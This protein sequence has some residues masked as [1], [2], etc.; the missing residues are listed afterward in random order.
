MQRADYL[1]LFG[2]E[3]GKE[4][5]L[6]REALAHALDIRKFEI[7]TYWK[8][9]TYFWA[10]IAVSFGGFFAL[11][12]R[13]TI[14]AF[15]VG[16][17]G[18]LFSVGWYLVNRGSGSW[19]RNWEA[20]VDLLEDEVMGPLHKTLI[21]RKKQPFGDLAGPYPFS[22]SRINNILSLCVVI[23]W[24]LLLILLCLRAPDTPENVFA[25]SF[26]IVLTAIATTSLIFHGR[27]SRSPMEPRE[28]EARTR[29]Y[30]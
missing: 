12:S 2:A 19:Q 24:V 4:S 6:Q 10:L 7:E 18:L 25:I 30:R 26:L 23:S 8:R 5:S 16:C 17:L 9:A 28:I 3:I 20:H 11:A 1:A 27:S 13:E 22:P 14:G 29:N 21:N 15:L